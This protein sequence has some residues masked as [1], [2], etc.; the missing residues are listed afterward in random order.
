MK[1]N[2]LLTCLLLAACPGAGGEKLDVSVTLPATATASEVAALH[3]WVVTGTEGH[4]ASCNLLVAGAQEPY[5]VELQLLGQGGART[6]EAL[7]ATVSKREGV[8]YVV[9]FDY[10]GE[11][12]YAGCSPV[13]SASPVT[14]TLGTF[15]VYDC[16]DANTPPGARC[17]DANLCTLGERCRGGSCTGGTARDCSALSGPCSN[18]TC[19]PATGCKKV[20]TN[21]GQTCDDGLFCTGSGT[22]ASGTCAAPP[23]TCPPAPEQCLEAGF[24]SE[25]HDRCI[26]F[27]KRS[28]TPCD[29]GNPCRTGDTCNS[30]GVC[31]AGATPAS[32]VTVECDRNAC[33]V[34]DFCSL[35]SCSPGTTFA[36][37]GTSCDDRNP[38]T[39]NESCSGASSAC[40]TGGNASAGT[41]CWDS[42]YCTVA[43]QCSGFSGTCSGGPTVYDY[44]G[45]GCARPS[46]AAFFCLDCDDTDPGT[47]SYY[48]SERCGDSKDNDCDGTIDE[49]GCVP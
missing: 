44:D 40:V 2:I 39:T 12:R 48:A 25:Q 24:C 49:V 27:P 8:V 15:K 7:I 17:D 32:D 43:D 38:C 31:L 11:P 45:D 22:C 3:A 41:P 10:E 6:G 47:N 46:C 18:G 19:D 21:E 34:G 13:T 42:S 9:A 33:T 28:G 23:I 4:E 14:V 30:A 1:R 26:Y 5:D 29:D 20:S 37:L 36:A 35:G 16:A